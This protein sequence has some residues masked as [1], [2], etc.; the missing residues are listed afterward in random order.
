MTNTEAFAQRMA[1]A[2]R[3]FTRHVVDKVDLKDIA[4]E[5]GISYD[6]ARADLAAF[7]KY[8]AEDQ[9]AEL[10]IKRA[11]FLA[12]LDANMRRALGVY[13]ACMAAGKHLA[14]IAALNTINAAL[15][16]KRAVEGLDMPKEVKAD[17][18]QRVTIMWAD[19]DA[20]DQHQYPTD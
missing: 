14:A 19:E 18:D 8:I 9:T 2:D 5:E 15:T 20:P 17:V 13:D 4:P 16:H 6:T 12:E 7:R 3:V 1:R 10:A 11:S